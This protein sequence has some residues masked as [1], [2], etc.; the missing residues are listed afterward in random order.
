MNVEHVEVLVEE[1]SMEAALRLLLPKIFDRTSYKIYS[2]QCKAELL[3]RLP[4]RLRGYASWLPKNWCIVV[5]VDQDN[6]NCI[7]LKKKLE[8]MAAD[9]GLTTRSTVSGKPYAV[10]NRLAIEELEAWYFGDWAAVRAAYPRVQE[11]IP[12]KASY[13][14]PDAI[15]GGTWE[16]LER[17]LQKAG[18]FKGGLRKI[19]AAY[20]IASHMNPECNKSHSYNV[21]LTAMQEMIAI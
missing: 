17:E 2:H 6:D 7:A 15:P 12:M 5:I 10:V 4:S 9:A 11:T 8:K 1:Q 19:E 18:Y 13:R 14:K 21:F 16:A 20:A 3:Q